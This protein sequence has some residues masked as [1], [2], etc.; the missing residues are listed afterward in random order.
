M[1][2]L[3]DYQILLTRV[4]LSDSTGSSAVFVMKQLILKQIWSCT[5]ASPSSLTIAEDRSRKAESLQK[6]HNG[7]V[8]KNGVVV[9][10]TISSAITYQTSQ[11]LVLFPSPPLAHVPGSE[12]KAACEQCA[13]G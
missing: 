6:M 7:F 12:I 5:L 9:A 3:E 10:G 8:G 11:C 4:C 2:L 1:F 13:L